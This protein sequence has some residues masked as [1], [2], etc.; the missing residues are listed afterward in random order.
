M[1]KQGESEFG[2][3]RGEDFLKTIHLDPS[4][5]VRTG[6]Y[7]SALNSTLSELRKEKTKP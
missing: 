3:R 4:L 6:R 1:Q 7:V 2:L 5:K